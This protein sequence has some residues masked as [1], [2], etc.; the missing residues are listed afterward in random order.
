MIPIG[1]YG[2]HYSG[3]FNKTKRINFPSRLK[4]TFNQ[5]TGSVGKLYC[6]RD[7][8]EGVDFLSLWDNV[9]SKEGALEVN[10]DARGRLQFPKGINLLEGELTW[11]GAGDHMEIY[12]SPDWQEIKDNPIYERI[13]E[14]IHPRH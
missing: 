3:E 11:L 7:N 12:R 5:R 10:I 9:P 1:Y 13:L 8:E 6:L 2:T 14:R 4:K